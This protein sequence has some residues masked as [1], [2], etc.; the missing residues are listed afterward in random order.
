MSH[1]RQSVK[2]QNRV[3]ADPSC[4]CSVPQNKRIV[5][6]LNG[7][8]VKSAWGD[9]P[10]TCYCLLF[11]G[12]GQGGLAAIFDLYQQNL[13]E[14]HIDTMKKPL[15]LWG[16]YSMHLLKNRHLL[17]LRNISFL[18]VL[19][20]VGPVHAQNAPSFDA[21]VSGLERQLDEASYKVRVAQLYGRP[22]ADVGQGDEVR[23]ERAQDSSGLVLRIDRLENQ[24]RNLN[25]QIEQM[26]FQI[27][28]MEE[29]QR[30]FQQDVDFRLQQGAGGGAPNHAAP[31]KVP[32][33][34]SDADGLAP[35][36][37]VAQAPMPLSPNPGISINPPVVDANNGVTPAGG[38]SPRGNRRGDAFDPASQPNAPGAPR[39]L[40]SLPGENPGAVRPQQNAAI[41][42]PLGDDAD[43]PLDLSQGGANAGRR[44]LAAP[45]NPGFSHPPVANLNPPMGAPMVPGSRQL[46]APPPHI[47]STPAA[48]PGAAVNPGIAALPNA[49]PPPPSDYD[50]G[51]V[52]LKA[53]QYE[54]AEKSFASF[55]SGNPK[56]KLV[57]DATF[58][59]GESYFLRSRHREAAEQYLKISTTYGQSRK[60]PEAMLRLGQS[61]NALGAKEQACATFGEVPRKY[62]NASANVK[63]GA[64]RE[65]KK[66]QC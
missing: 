63:A 15:L 41:S 50:Q 27:R 14:V 64:E 37:V 45:A 18:A 32:Q 46:P 57:S 3:D 26:Q 11:Q 61:L 33:K 30:K 49:A 1:A 62:P 7:E 44:P 23:M 51:V 52:S 28:R 16:P 36:P 20:F 10:I 54:A 9:F 21:R 13:A 5:N 48:A 53:G 66:A 43:A 60:A 56:S 12:V 59:I 25:G 6:V 22:P 47:P 55:V 39:V 65:A 17:K 29:Q 2:D 34:R 38:A 42:G 31:P 35:A 19:A 8:R 24:M 4:A 40:G 58:Y